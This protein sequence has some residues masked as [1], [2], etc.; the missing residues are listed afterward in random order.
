MGAFVAVPSLVLA[1]LVVLSLAI[2]R[3][4]LTYGVPTSHGVA[5]STSRRCSLGIKV[6]QSLQG[7][8]G[9]ATDS[10]GDFCHRLRFWNHSRAT[11]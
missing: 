8:L 7:P 4:F 11:G 5:R 9:F 3:C 2:A 10:R 1:A 6:V